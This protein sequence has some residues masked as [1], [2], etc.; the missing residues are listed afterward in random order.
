MVLHAAGRPCY[1]PPR[2]G[3]RGNRSFRAQLIWAI[4]LLGALACLPNSDALGQE[5]PAAGQEAACPDLEAWCDEIL[6]APIYILVIDHS[7]SMLQNEDMTNA[8]GEA[9]NRWEYMRQ[10]AA[11]FLQQSP[12][13]T[14]VI[15]YVFEA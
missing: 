2:L 5:K 3:M 7:G 13:G 8:A 4:A 6:D 9:V 11:D 10:L 14:T 12:L 1:E 15:L